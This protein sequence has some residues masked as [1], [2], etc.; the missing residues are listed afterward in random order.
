[1]LSKIE[2]H[3]LFK[4]YRNFYIGRRHTSVDNIVKGLPKHTR[5]E[6]KKAVRSLIKRGYILSKPTSYGAQVSLNPRMIA[7]IKQAL[8]D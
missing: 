4:L 3:I 2:K 5:G 8:E 7:K 6:A 1:M